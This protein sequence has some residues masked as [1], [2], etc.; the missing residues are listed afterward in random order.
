M[1]IVLLSF[2]GSL[3]TKCVFLSNQ[4]CIDRPTLVNL[5]PIDLKYHPFMIS[6]G[7]CNV[8]VNAVDDLSTKICVPSKTKHINVKV[9]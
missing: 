6:L 9:F 3:A 7:K 4:Q 8:H 1:F 5:N 2:N